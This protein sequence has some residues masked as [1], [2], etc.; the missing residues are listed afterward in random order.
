MKKTV[1][2]QTALLSLKVRPAAVSK[3]STEGVAVPRKKIAA[4]HLV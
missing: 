2:K 3:P 1:P 4:R